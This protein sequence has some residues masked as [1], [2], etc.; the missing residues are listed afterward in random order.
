MTANSKNT[1]RKIKLRNE[2]FGLASFFNWR[3]FWT[4][5]RPSIVLGVTNPFFAKTLQFW[6]N[7]VRLGFESFGSGVTK[8]KKGGDLKAIDAKPGVYTSYKPCL[9]KDKA[10]LKKLYKVWIIKKIILQ[11]FY[12]FIYYFPSDPGHPKKAILFYFGFEQFKRPPI[13]WRIT[14]FFNIKI[15]STFFMLLKFVCSIS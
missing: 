4:Y 1:R 10:F 15:S 12:S 14:I 2:W 7:I 13:I 3:K 11:I 6:P 5:F 8:L 9:A